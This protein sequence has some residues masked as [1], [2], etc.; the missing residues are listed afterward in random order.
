[1]LVVFCRRPVSGVGKQRVAAQLGK[2]ET[3]TLAA[4]LLATALEDAEAWPG[5]VVLS[6]ADAAD[7]RWAA[8]QLRR[9]CRVV[10]QSGGNLGERI[11]GVDRYLRRTGAEHLVFV[12]SDAPV[13]GE[14]YFAQSRAALMQHD[15]VLG[16]A[17][18]GGVTLMGSRTTWPDL[19]DLPW[20][21]D[22]LCDAL[23]RLCVTRGLTVHRLN[24]EYDIDRVSD[25]PRLLADL[26]TDRR[27]ARHRLCQWL[28]TI[29][30]PDARQT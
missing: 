18:D 3:Q 11:N 2:S 15:V 10:P 30:L 28:E 5:H 27:P 13:L 7:E 9:S 17:E 21:T 22:R 20:S 12:G 14:D 16:P 8:Q 25:L 24:S 4:L 23:E 26:R 1:M 6:P 19:A 29:D